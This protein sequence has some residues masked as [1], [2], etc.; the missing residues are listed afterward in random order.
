[1][2]SW[3]APAPEVR[4]PLD[5]TH[6]PPGCLAIQLEHGAYR[7]GDLLRVRVS[8]STMV[9]PKKR[10]HTRNEL[11]SF[12]GQ[13]SQVKLPKEFN[14]ALL[15]SPASNQ[16]RQGF[17]FA[18]RDVSRISVRFVGRRRLLRE[19]KKELSAA[20][21]KPNN[22]NSKDDI[23]IEGE[24]Y[25]SLPVEIFSREDEVAALRA[26]SVSAMAAR[27]AGEEESHSNH[28]D[29]DGNDARVSKSSRLGSYILS[30]RS[31]IASI[32][33]PQSLPPSYRGEYSCVNY[34]I[35]V[36]VE[37]IEAGQKGPCCITHFKLP[38]VLRGVHNSTGP[39]ATVSACSALPVKILRR[40]RGF[41]F[42]ESWSMQ[43]A[44]H[45]SNERIM[46]TSSYK[47]M[48][49][50]SHLRA[51]S[52]EDDVS[53]TS[54]DHGACPVRA[55][56][57]GAPVPLT[58]GRL[59]ERTMFRVHTTLD[60]GCNNA[61]ASGKARRHIATV[62]LYNF[63]PRASE[64]ISVHINFMCNNSD[65]EKSSNRLGVTVDTRCVFVCVALVRCEAITLSNS[66]RERGGLQSGMNN[67]SSEEARKWITVCRFNESVR[68]ACSTW[69]SLPVPEDAL[70][71]EDSHITMSWKLKFAFKVE[72]SQRLYSK[73]RLKPIA[74]EPPLMQVYSFE[75]PVLI[76]SE[77]RSEN[78]Y[79]ASHDGSPED[80]VFR[81]T[82]RW[83]LTRV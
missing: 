22:L 77:W 65:D 73:G 1:M 15:G 68:N 80:S 74:S 55:G 66:L 49:T 18:L 56:D 35:A 27:H 70:S 42:H 29:G 23:I 50:F 8:I 13:H 46:T 41:L 32:Q 17:D 48:V 67:L 11:L 7:A 61:E 54:L 52:F 75:Y 26:D 9:R 83:G 24:F 58:S 60:K 37:T 39:D 2:L 82:L 76:S 51:C 45:D 30:D 53:S 10:A 31:C 47:K 64:N 21:L 43:A 16:H 59:S 62:T 36:E 34:Y 71:M 3:F 69:C 63:S 4:P 28:E 5:H 33:L 81:G 38:L 44:V 40:P 12:G 72:V 78:E 25:Q 57:S 14:Y 19:A 6:S 79:V 20:G